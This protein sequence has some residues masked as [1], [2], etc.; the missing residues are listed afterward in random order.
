[1]SLEKGFDTKLCPA[2]LRSPLC[3]VVATRRLERSSVT[4][5]TGEKGG[6]R[7]ILKD[8]Y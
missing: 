6:H 2:R 4:G 3:V 1:M 8:S 7:I 5:D